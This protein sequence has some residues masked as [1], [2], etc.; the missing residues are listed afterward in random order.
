[1]ERQGKRAEALE[2][3]DR[4]LAADPQ[5]EWA[6]VALFYKARFC[7]E[8]AREPDARAAIARLR[9]E[10]PDSSYVARAAVLEAELDGRSTA[11]AEAALERELAAAA[12]YDAGMAKSKAR[13]D[14]EALADLRRVPAEF[15]G[16]AAA[17]RALDAEGHILTRNRR[18]DEALVPFLRILEATLSAAPNA[19]I[20]EIAATRVAALHHAL[21][22]RDLALRTYLDI[23]ESEGLTARTRANALLQGSGVYFEILQRRALRQGVTDEQWDELRQMLTVAQT[24][25]GVS[26]QEAKIAR[27]MH[28]ESWSWQRQREQVVAELEAFLADYDDVADR[29]EVATARIFGAIAFNHLGRHA[30]ALDHAEW[31]IGTYEPT[32]WIWPTHQGLPRAYFEAFRAREKLG[33]M[34]DELDHRAAEME[35]WFPDRSETRIAREIAT[36]TLDDL[37]RTGKVFFPEGANR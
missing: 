27:L 37:I 32:D 3:Y 25:E 17:L 6:P 15:P 18:F 9:A 34:R 20:S 1:Q 12:V 16:S 35:I 4:A 2:S 23:A 24:A 7:K 31:V 11:A 30:E 19:R 21:N 5:G 33:A 8:G 10:H 26:H 28:L 14:E 29:R 13:A 22:D 36:P